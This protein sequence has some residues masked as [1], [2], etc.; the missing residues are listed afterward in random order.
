[1]GNLRPIVSDHEKLT[2]AIGIGVLTRLLT[3]DLVVDAAD[4]REKRVRLLPARAMFFGTSCEEVLRKLAHGLQT[5]GSWR[6]ERTAPT[7]GAISKA[8]MRPD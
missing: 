3:R 4:R 8:R 6:K 7:V 2:D 5:V 1:M